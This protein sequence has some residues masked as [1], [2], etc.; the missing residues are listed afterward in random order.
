MCMCMCI[1]SSVQN[2]DTR[3]ERASDQAVKCAWRK[4]MVGWPWMGGRMDGMNGMVCRGRTEILDVA[5]ER[6]TDRRCCCRAF[7][8]LDPSLAN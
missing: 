2:L 7:P 1:A 6:E 8:S 3:G 4:M 5:S